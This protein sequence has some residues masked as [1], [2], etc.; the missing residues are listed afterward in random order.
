MYYIFTYS[1]TIL[2]TESS[3]ETA[4]QQ[5]KIDSK[6]SCPNSFKALLAIPVSKRKQQPTKKSYRLTNPTEPLAQHI[7]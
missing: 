5:V 6:T 2:V 7:T 1:K 4:K 3:Y